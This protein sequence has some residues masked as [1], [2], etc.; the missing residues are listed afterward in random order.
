MANEK[1][2]RRG[3]E[4]KTDPKRPMDERGME[5]ICC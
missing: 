4:A 2:R 3:R 5:W 1:R